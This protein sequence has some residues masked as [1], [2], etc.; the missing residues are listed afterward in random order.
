LRVLLA[1]REHGVVFW[2]ELQEAFFGERDPV[3]IKS[4]IDTTTFQIFL[5]LRLNWKCPSIKAAF[6]SKAAESRAV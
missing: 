2:N 3:G 1:A 6:H 5:N 4:E